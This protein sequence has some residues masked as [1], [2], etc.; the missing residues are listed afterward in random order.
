L[1]DHK[2]PVA[3]PADGLNLWVPLRQDSQPVVFALAK[4]GWLVRNGE[5]FSVQKVIPG[6]R[7]TISNLDEVDSW[8]LAQ[9][10]RHNL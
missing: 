3:T 9:D 6:L 1:A 7:I 4:H 5:A 2:I 8:R 10:I